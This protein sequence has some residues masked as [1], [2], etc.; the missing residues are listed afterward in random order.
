MASREKYYIITMAFRMAC[1]ISMFFLSGWIRWVV[2]GGAVFL[3]IIAVLFANQANTKS[4]AGTV[5]RGEPSQAP[6]LTAGSPAA[7]VI[8]GELV[9]DDAAEARRSSPTMTG[10]AEDDERWGQRDG[11]HDRVA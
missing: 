7:D 5:Q 8:E 11:R 2:L 10:N 1:F 4:T 6:Q 3:P 9:G